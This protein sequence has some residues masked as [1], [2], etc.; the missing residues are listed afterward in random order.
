MF[1]VKNRGYNVHFLFSSKML[2]V[3]W[4]AALTQGNPTVSHN[5]QIYKNFMNEDCVESLFESPDQ[6]T[7]PG[8]LFLKRPGANRHT[9]SWHS[10]CSQ[11]V[12]SAI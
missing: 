4:L 3:V 6:H 11:N 10:K 8:E 2:I 7:L 12:I 1:Y 5:V 9:I